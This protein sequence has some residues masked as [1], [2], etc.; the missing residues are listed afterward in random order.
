MRTPRCCTFLRLS[1][2]ALLSLALGCAAGAPR[3]AAPLPRAEAA[4]PPRRAILVSFDALNE[5]RLRSSLDPASVPHLLAL[6]DS[7]ACA[8]HAVP[9]F[10]SVTAA[11]HASLWTGAYGNVNGVVANSQPRL[12]AD[13]HTLL[14]AV[15]GFS[16]EALRAEPLWITAARAGRIVV[17]HHV[18]QAPQPPAYL[19]IAGAAAPALATRRAD[20]ERVLAG[21]NVRV[22]NGYNRTVE[23]DRVLTERTTPPRPAHGWAHLERL[24]KIGVELREVAWTVGGDSVFALLYGEHE[25]DRVLVAPR[26]DAA[27]GVVARA[28]AAER[29]PLGERPLARHFSAPLALPVE[30]GQVQLRVRLFHL[31]PDGTAF[32]LFQPALHVVEANRPEV[33]AEYD[34]A[35]RGWAGNS[36]LRALLAGD[37][38]PTLL[39]GGDG[40]A[41]ARYLESVEYMTRQFM[42]GTQWAWA[43]LGAELLLDYFPLGDEIDHT[44]YGYLDPRWPGYDPALA[45]RIQQVRQR[46][47]EMVDLRLGHLQRLVAETPGAALFVAGDHGMRATWRVFRPNAVLREAGLLVLNGGG[48]IDLARTRVLSPTG[49]WL[50]VNRAARAGGVVPPDREAAVLAAAERALLSARDV[51]GTPVITRVYRATEH[52]ELGLGGPAGGDLYFGTAPG[53]RWAADPAGSVVEAAGIAAGHGFPSVEPDMWTVFCAQGAGF[54]GRRSGPVRTIDVAPTV[55]AWLGVPARADAVGRSVLAELAATVPT[56]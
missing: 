29:A 48:Q 7:A 39:Q 20:A 38:G 40:A 53:V 13:R 8:A 32:M 47:W 41:E 25:F 4:A 1:P 34:A 33:Q 35:V 55:A 6:F 9:A 5:A 30:G 44:Y 14:D 43:S 49:Q 56:R 23:G 26:R 28:A 19:P 51:D 18:T 50:S 11:G 2:V 52:P 31:A 27:L 17:G 46:A 37:F 22:L 42:R 10:P 3:S 21:A 54:P 24:G 36:A 12:P 45:A 16:A 15:S